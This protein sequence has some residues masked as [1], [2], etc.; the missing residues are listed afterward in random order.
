MAEKTKKSKKVKNPDEKLEIAQKIAAN[1]QK[2]AR[3]YATLENA[4]LYVF[5]SASDFLT[6]A[7]FNKKFSK[8]FS[9]ILAII[10]YISVN[11]SSSDTIGISQ[12]ATL[13][14]VPVKTVYNSEIYEVSGIPETVNV[15]VTGSMSDITL[16][17]GKTNST[18]TCDLSGLT[19]GTYT[20]K[21][22][23]ENFSS[24][25]SVN[26]LDNPT[27]TVT[28]K[29]KITTKYNISYEFI[30]KNAMDSTYNLGETTFDST[31]VLIR[32]SQD[33]ID[34][35]AFVKALIDVT[36]V[37]E[38]FTREARLVAY[39]NNGKIVDCDIIPSTVMATVSVTS[40]SKEVPII[41]RTTGTMGEGLALDQV[42]LDHSTVTI[43]AAN[44]VL[45]L[46]DAIYVDLDVSNITK[47]TSLSTT[48][49]M[50][51]GVNKM[52]VT[53]INMEIVVGEK[54]SRVISDVKVAYSGLNSNFKVKLVDESDVTLNIVVYG[55]K[56]NIDKLTADDIT[57][58][59]DLSQVTTVG[60]QQAP[61]TVTGTNALVEYEVEDQ[62]KYIEI[63]IAE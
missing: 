50:P 23:P 59:I 27:V 48:L 35:I 24:E 31:E 18:V 29:K 26:V 10:L 34:S 61:L 33:T 56:S 8:V 32:A 22:V 20:I 54:T 45:N 38:S 16:Q 21:L 5:R 47:D 2:V 7:I 52:D 6:K 60:V 15:I 43:Y 57:V 49:N 28:I 44:S 9:L 4:F 36:G 46:I 17:K 42:S 37:T 51:S 30:N 53:K 63:E 41:V 39:D 19:E 40:P 55:T 12:S 14:D 25:L 62:R 1:S 11:V 58:S 3:T 13:T